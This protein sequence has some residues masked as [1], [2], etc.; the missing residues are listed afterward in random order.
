MFRLTGVWLSTIFL[1]ICSMHAN[2]RDLRS[3]LAIPDTDS[4]IECL[5]GRDDPQPNAM[6]QPQ[7]RPRFSTS[8]NCAK[9][10]SSIEVTIC[11]D[12]E[13]AQ[14][15]LQ[16]GQL[17]SEA[18]KGRN[19]NRTMISEQR[20]W[21][22]SRK[23]KCEQASQSLILAC[24][25]QLTRDRIA[26]LT[27]ISTV[28]T[29]KP[30]ERNENKNIPNE[31]NVSSISSHPSVDLTATAP[32]NETGRP[33]G[34]KAA[35]AAPERDSLIQNQAERDALFK[36]L[37]ESA[38]NY[39]FKYVVINLPPGT[40][41]GKNYI[42]PV[43][44]IRYDSTV[45]FSFN[46][47]TLEAGAELILRDLVSVVAKDPTLRSLLVVGHT[48]SIGTDDYNTALSKRRAF[49]V[50]SKLQAAGVNGKYVGVIPMGKAQPIATNKT[51]EG[52]AQNRRVEFFI[53]DV[54]EATEKA[55][56]LAPFNP[57]FRNDQNAAADSPSVKC[58][59]TLVRVPIYGVD[60]EN[61]ARGIIPLRGKPDERPKLPI[62]ILTRPSLQELNLQ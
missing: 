36:A 52:R 53:S 34:A 27:A 7:A 44:H 9:A 20:Q 60:S 31:P 30:R 6:V 58:D 1:A 29:T 61:K 14:L 3:C 48:D 43:S 32:I 8:F 46:S 55:V 12:S 56:E 2:A 11:S 62:V 42:I 33:I 21:L 24:L 13:L 16:M 25:M 38:S 18:L 41:P 39:S 40:F 47:S 50:A 19:N 59:T 23:S 54:P 49:T 51:E 28:Q 45:L 10:V 26:N 17:Y 15:D 4:K 22:S 5:E 37:K 35:H 57:C